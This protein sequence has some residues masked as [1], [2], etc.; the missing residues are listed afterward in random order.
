MNAIISKYTV[1][2]ILLQ[3]NIL[4]DSKEGQAACVIAWT[5][6]TFEHNNL[7][8]RYAKKSIR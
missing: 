3:C 6:I 7:V 8:Q 4:Q 1:F 2:H 5:I